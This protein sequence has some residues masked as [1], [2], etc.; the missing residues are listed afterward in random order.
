M[1]PT[2]RWPCYPEPLSKA[3]AESGSLHVYA[4]AAA[5]FPSRGNWHRRLK[6][7]NWRLPS[8]R[9]VFTEGSDEEEDAASR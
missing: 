2:G 1:H 3:W 4:S 6:Q 9:G 5:S 8:I 7:R